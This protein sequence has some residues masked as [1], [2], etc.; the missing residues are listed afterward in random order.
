MLSEPRERIALRMTALFCNNP[1]ERFYIYRSLTPNSLFG[2][3]YLTHI[4]QNINYY[5]LMV[6]S[7]MTTRTD[8]QKYSKH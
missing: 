8:I 5:Q 7:H 6:F 4:M 3:T 2:C 1:I